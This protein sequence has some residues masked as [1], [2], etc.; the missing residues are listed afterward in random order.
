MN[1][2]TRKA[3][4]TV[5]GAIGGAK[6]GKDMSPKHPLAGAAGGGFVGGTFGFLFSELVNAVK[7]V[8][9]RGSDYQTTERATLGRADYGEI[10]GLVRGLGISNAFFEAYNEVVLPEIFSFLEP[11]VE[12]DR[13]P[14]DLDP[15]SIISSMRH[16][17]F[18]VHE[19]ALRRFYA[20]VK[21]KGL[22]EVR[23]R[24]IQLDELPFELDAHA[25]SAVFR[26]WAE[27]K[28]PA[29]STIQ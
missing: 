21:T 6:L 16:Q 19:E 14:P 5:A 15:V 11:Y 24:G 9:A 29:Q 4:G 10:R 3:L 12:Q 18:A 27:A 8:G 7:E 1:E 23:R 22:A 28:L 2:K 25:D 26:R 17:I 13:E 20:D